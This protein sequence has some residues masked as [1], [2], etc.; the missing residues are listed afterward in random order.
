MYKRLELH[1]HT[2][3]S[4]ASCTCR[5]LTELMADDQVDAFALTDHNT[6]SG[7]KKIQAILEET[8]LPISFIPGMEYTTYYGHILCLNLKEYVPWENI[9]KHKPELL[10]LAARAKGALVGIA[11]PFSYGWPFARVAGL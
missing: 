5:E 4:D 2:N 8:H 1:N 10:F 6:I 11:H 7:H 9:N 3:E